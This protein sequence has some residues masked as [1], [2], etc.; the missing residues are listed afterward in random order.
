MDN[1]IT[2][3]KY[4]E[5]NKRIK[6][7]REVELPEASKSKLLAAEEGDL[8][9]NAGYHAAKERMQ[10]LAIQLGELEEM[11]ASPKFIEDLNIKGDIVTLGTIVKVLDLKLKR[12]TEYSILGPGDSDADNNIISFQTPIARGLM[13]KKPG[14]QCDIPTPSGMKSYKILSVRTYAAG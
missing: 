12:E 2:K 11:V 9:E 10:L 14:D 5:L 7:I 6:H 8:K 4:D 13:R 3:K 1:Y